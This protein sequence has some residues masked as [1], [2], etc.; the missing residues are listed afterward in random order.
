MT[1]EESIASFYADPLGYVYFAFPWGKPGVL[2]NQE[3]PD[4]WQVDVLRDLGNGTISATEAVQLAVTSGHGI[5]K[6]CLVAWIIL[7]FIST[8]PH[9][10]IVVTANTKTQ[11]ETKTWR[12]L[13]KWH[14]LAINGAWFK[15]S[16]QRFYLIEH[17]ETWFA[18]CI[19]WS[20]ER[21][22]AFAGT[23]EEHVLVVFDEASMVDDVIWEV[24]EGAMTQSGAF[25]V[26]FGNPTRNSGRFHGCF[27]RW[28]HRWITRQIDSRTAKMANKKQIDKWAEDYG[29]D[30]D[31]FR[32]RVKGQF[33]RV[34]SMQFIPTDIVV[35]ARGKHLMLDQYGHAPRIIAVDVARYGDD[36]SVICK[37]QGLFCHPFRKFRGLDTMTLAGKVADEIKEFQPDAVFVDETGI[38]AGVIDR[39]RQLGHEIIGVNFGGEAADKELYHRKGDE[40]WGRTRDWL[41]SGAAIPDDQELEDELTAREYGYSA[42]NAYQLEKKS[43]MKER[44]LSSPD[45]ADALV[46]TFAE[47]VMAR[48]DLNEITS[49][50]PTQYDPFANI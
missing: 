41:K 8:R 45:V 32:V 27:N 1:L 39:L 26:A 14:K 13:A 47:H 33:P 5:G 25:W 43:D 2:A 35:A 34:G 17:P 36:Q 31:F 28:K 44:G 48:H 6:S 49:D 10:Q 12:E 21:S 18:A 3:G 19:P 50:E 29:D 15:W 20:K 7:W 11:L 4:T 46:L 40:M 30:S 23:H 24:T 9:P 38:G 16:A 22:E 42:K 37:R